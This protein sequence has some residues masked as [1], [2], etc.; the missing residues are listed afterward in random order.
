MAFT[1]GRPP[2]EK[3]IVFAMCLAIVD[4]GRVEVDVVGDQEFARADHGGAG[5]RMQARLAD[6]RRAV[7]IVQHFFAQAFE[8]PFADIFEIRALGPLR[9][10]FVEIDGNAIALPDFARRFLGES[11]AIFDRD[12]VDRDEGNHIGRADARMRARLPRQVDQLGG[13]AH[14]AHRRFARLLP[15]RPPA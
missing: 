11:D 8:L 4:V 1:N 6:I 2:L 13:F 15:A 14:A 3:R 12:A 7:G 5:R 9:G 10:R